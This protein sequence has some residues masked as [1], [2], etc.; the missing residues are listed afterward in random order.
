[1]RDGVLLFLP[2]LAALGPAI[3]A[4]GKPGACVAFHAGGRINEQRRVGPGQGTGVAICVGAGA[5]LFRVKDEISVTSQAF[6]LNESPDLSG[7]RVTTTGLFL[8]GVAHYTATRHPGS[9]HSTGTVSGTLTALFD[10]PG[11]QPLVGTGFD[12][13]LS[14]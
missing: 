10:T 14:C 3:D 4:G 9:D 2:R 5:R 7:A 8:S 13:Y 12:A 6:K 11:P 1:M